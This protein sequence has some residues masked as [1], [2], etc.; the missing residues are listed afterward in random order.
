MPQNIEYCQMVLRT[1]KEVELELVKHQE[2]I[3]SFIQS[4]SKIY[5]DDF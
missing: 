2:T 3:N 4:S 1:L 5:S